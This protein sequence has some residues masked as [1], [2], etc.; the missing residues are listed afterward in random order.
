[1][2]FK[3]LMIIFGITTTIIVGLLL[4][5]SYAYYVASNPNDTSFSSSTSNEDL[6]LVFA[7]SQNINTT[8]GIPILASEVADKA[9]K[10]IFNLTLGSNLSTHTVAVKVSLSNIVIDNNLK[11]ASFK[12]QL[13]KNGSSVASGDFASVTGNVMDLTSLTTLNVGSYPAT[14]N[15]ELRVW[16]E[17]ICSNVTD[18]TSCS[19]YSAWQSAYTAGTE[20][21]PYNSLNSTV[22]GQNRMMGKG[23][24]AKIEVTSAIK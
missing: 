14:I 5:F 11:D 3:K 6:S 19:D 18:I 21:Y 23:F 13:L 2:E 22:Y 7:Q 10:N 8:I 16:L 24:S 4:S 9:T 12:W 20:S 17:E 1:M 15:Y